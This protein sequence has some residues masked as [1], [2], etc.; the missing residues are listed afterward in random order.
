M[1]A[2][3]FVQA[4][5]LLLVHEGGK[6][7]DPHDPGGRTNWGITHYDYDAYRRSKGLPLRD[8]FLMDDSER[9]DIYRT[10]YWNAI[11]GDD[12]PSGLDYVVFDGGVNSG[13]GQSIKWLQRALPALPANGRLSDALVSQLA[14]IADLAALIEAVCE[15]RREFLRNL[16]TFQYFGRGWIKRVDDVQATALAWASGSTPPAPTAASSSSQ[17]KALRESGSALPSTAPGDVIAAAGAAGLAAT[18]VGHAQTPPAPQNSPTSSAVQTTSTPTAVPSPAA[19][20]NPS[21]ATVVPSAPSAPAAASTMPPAPATAPAAQA[22]VAKTPSQPSA[23]PSTQPTSPAASPTASTIAPAATPAAPAAAGKPPVP[24]IAAPASTVTPAPPSPTAANKLSP[25]VVTAS[26][27]AK[28]AATPTTAPAASAT[29]ASATPAK[30]VAPTPKPP[31]SSPVAKP[32]IATAPHAAPAAKAPAAH[33]GTVVAPSHP[34]AAPSPFSA[35]AIVLAI[36]MLIGLY[37][38]FSS[39][40]A[41][42]RRL[43]ALGDNPLPKTPLK[44]AKPVAAA[45]KLPA[46]RPAAPPPPPPPMPTA[47]N[48]VLAIPLVKSLYARAAA[49]AWICVTIAVNVIVLAK[50]L[51]GFGFAHENWHQPFLWLGNTYDTYAGQAFAATQR[52]LSEQFGFTLPAWILPAFV[53]YVSMA[54][55]FVVASSGLM[56]R[57]S[58]AESFIAAVLHAGWVFAVPS[59]VIN[60]VRYRVVTRFARQNSVLF[61]AYLLA[62]VVAY[63]GARFINDDILPGFAARN[64]A[65]LQPAAA[66]ANL[67]KALGAIVPGGR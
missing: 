18:L 45:R 4:L 62:F 63:V 38:S 2:A 55:A 8:V 41:R 39:R 49:T 31:P 13:N 7:D 17:P 53:L 64:G 32:G 54:S 25:P 61:F 22:T 12:L 37:V 36:V 33:P 35:T 6:T 27:P 47:P 11:R 26:V 57:D 40:K 59:F 50:L 46:A 15:A 10:V 20:T 43:D 44:T 58:N 30:V 66:A 28:T 48:G 60:A 1:A 5:A 29:P 52:S 16:D 21:P 56:R 67:E 3:N 23:P 14:Q 34:V 42:A 65:L 19:A 24:V 51:Q 9:D